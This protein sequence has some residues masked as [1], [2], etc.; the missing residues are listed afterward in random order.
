MFV[1][2]ASVPAPKS[3]ID[4]NGGGAKMGDSESSFD[5]ILSEQTDNFAV[6]NQVNPNPVASANSIDVD[7]EMEGLDLENPATLLNPQELSA[8]VK[9]SS[10]WLNGM[11]LMATD[12]STKNNAT[13]DLKAASSA[14]SSI[15]EETKSD[16]NAVLAAMAAAQVAQA[17][18][19]T[20]QPI[21]VQNISSS[22]NNAH[23]I[24]PQE[25]RLMPVETKILTPVQP[26]I[27]TIDPA[28]E[29]PEDLTSVIDGKVNDQIKNTNNPDYNKILRSVDQPE[30]LDLKVQDPRLAPNEN[31]QIDVRPPLSIQEQVAL[32]G[33]KLDLE[34]RGQTVQ[35]DALPFSSLGVLHQT[36][37]AKQEEQLKYKADQILTMNANTTQSIMDMNLMQ[38]QRGVMNEISANPQI[39]NILV[40]TGQQ[41]YPQF[42]VSSGNIPRDIA[43][44]ASV[45]NMNEADRQD[46]YAETQNGNNSLN[47]FDSILQS[48]SESRLTQTD[49]S[50]NV[51]NSP[52][53]QAMTTQTRIDNLDQIAH[54]VS[55]TRMDQD[56]QELIMQLQPEHLGK[57]TMKVRKD[58]DDIKVDMLVDNIAAKRLLE[59]N[60]S[61]LRSR[62]QQNDANFGSL[63]F[64]V[65]VDTNASSDNSQQQFTHN[66]GGF[67]G[68]YANQKQAERQAASI[69][70]T[71]A[72]TRSNGASGLNI[73]A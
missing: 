10:E 17:Q 33:Q 42:Q 20:N 36:A 41:V 70:I 64:S 67:E 8:P 34:S 59:V 58:G 68:D 61:D 52:T 49:K 5:E 60:L 31:L 12:I 25:L 56:S 66:R 51:V 14:D 19:I 39:Q 3:A 7:A 50:N 4:F 15:Q 24:E 16:E 22:S 71:R 21:V 28:Q 29:M 38:Q 46:S 27:I 48:N 2:F 57:M 54:M 1:N 13:G 30:A 73:Y 45:F 9:A 47:S 53:S 35:S 37:V 11:G 18:S 62:F 65:D 69:P 43:G 40:P 44:L 63:T 72:Y 32:A 6:V 26:D 23:K 55:S